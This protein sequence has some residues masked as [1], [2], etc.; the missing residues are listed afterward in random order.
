MHNGTTLSRGSVSETIDAAQLL[1]KELKVTQWLKSDSLTGPIRL[2]ATYKDANGNTVGSTDVKTLDISGIT[3]W[4]QQTYT[5]NVPNNSN[6]K[7]ITIEYV[8][9]N[10][11]GALWVDGI[12]GE[13]AAQV[14]TTNLIS[15]GD[16][17]EG[18]SYWNT[19]KSSGDF[20]VNT[21]TSVKK[22]GAKSLKL[23]NGT[24][25]S[26]GGVSETIDAAQLLGKAIKVTHWLKSDR[27]TGSIRL[28]TTYKDVNGNTVG[29]TDVKTIGISGTTDWNQQTYTINVPN[30]ASIKNMTVEY[31][32]DNCT[33]VIWMDDITGVK[34]Q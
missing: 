1:G 6:I 11:T 19:W 33:G 23:H 7:N 15:N 30:D 9:D 21:D 32:Y 27:L 24:T 17:E 3:D 29:S 10:C 2:R 14:V 8:Y 12:D 18:Q 16:F 13:S 26:R 34:I 25:L 31:L 28:R 22:N 4:N 5:F 20:S